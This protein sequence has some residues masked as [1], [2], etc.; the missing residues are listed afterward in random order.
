MYKDF[1]H[2]PSKVFASCEAINDLYFNLKKIYCLELHTFS[3]LDKKFI[4]MYSGSL[5]L[6]DE[7]IIFYDL[8]NLKYKNRKII[9]PEEI[10]KAFDNDSIL[11]FTNSNKLKQY[12]YSKNWK[13]SVL[14]MMSSGD[15]GGMRWDILK[16]FFK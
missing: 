3:S 16:S 5:N 15:F 7:A 10:R 12:L 1:A 8:N 9:L 11:I 14:L 4:K 6:S 2:S 13:N